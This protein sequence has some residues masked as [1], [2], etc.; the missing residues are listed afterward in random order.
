[1]SNTDHPDR[2]YYPPGCTGWEP[3]IVG[4]EEEEDAE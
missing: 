4:Y 1:M 3:E 2:D